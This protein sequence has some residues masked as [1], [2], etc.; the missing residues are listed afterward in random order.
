MRDHRDR[1]TVAMTRDM[2]RPFK[3]AQ[4]FPAERWSLVVLWLGTAAVSAMGWRGISHS[5]VAEAGW[6]PSELVSPVVLG[7]IALDLALGMA[8]TIWPSVW[9]SRVSFAVVVVF[10]LLAT[11][12]VPAMWLHPLGPLLKNL[13]I[14]A[15]LWRGCGGSSSQTT[16]ASPPTHNPSFD[17]GVCHGQ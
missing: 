7:G 12:M 16:P 10:S 11:A 2:T 8:W 15:L 14:L 9:V 1:L 6:V 13:P 17:Q 5:L 3:P 4:L